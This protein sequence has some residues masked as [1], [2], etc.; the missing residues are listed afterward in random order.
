[1]LMLLESSQ[2]QSMYA[3]YSIR[4]SIYSNIC[5]YFGQDYLEVGSS[6]PEW[7][8]SGFHFSSEHLNPLQNSQYA[9]EQTNLDLWIRRC[10]HQSSFVVPG[11]MANISQGQ[12]RVLKEAK[13]IFL[14]HQGTTLKVSMLVSV[15]HDI[16]F[17][18]ISL[19]PGPRPTI[20]EIFHSRQLLY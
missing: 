1:M 17:N 6:N 14:I 8:Q 20:K 16:T 18:D 15:F 19:R 11:V 12:L 13:D 4:E 9:I 7:Y 10:G 3:L 5:L 2:A